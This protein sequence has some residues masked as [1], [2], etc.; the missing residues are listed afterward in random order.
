MGLRWPV[1]SLYESLYQ[2]P[3]LIAIAYGKS[4]LPILMLILFRLQVLSP[5]HAFFLSFVLSLGGPRSK[6]ILWSRAFLDDS[7]H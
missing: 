7:H 5:L 1:G 4:W 3:R 6:S 2:I